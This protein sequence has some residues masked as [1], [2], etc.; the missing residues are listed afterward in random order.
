MCCM[1]RSSSGASGGTAQT[2]M[3]S[4]AGKRDAG[5]PQD[6]R[7]RPP[8]S[9]SGAGGVGFPGRAPERQEV[10]GGAADP[11]DEGNEE[12]AIVLEGEGPFEGVVEGPLAGAQGAE[13][14]A[15]DGEG[16]HV[17]P[18]LCGAG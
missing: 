9:K 7:G 15:Q 11:D 1:S 5:E 3:R 12:G 10:E 8:G 13:A 2:C 17:L 18:P 16:H 4:T 6:Y 14:D